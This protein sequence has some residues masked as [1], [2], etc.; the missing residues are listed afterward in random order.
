MGI[1]FNV[2]QGLNVCYRNMN[3]CLQIKEKLENL[4][5]L[6]YAKLKGENR[7][8]DEVKQCIYGSC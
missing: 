5:K 7:F 6:C 4:K 2:F 8:V 1:F 3:I